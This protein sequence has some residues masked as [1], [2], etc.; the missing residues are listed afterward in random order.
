MV[1]L[2]ANHAAGVS[3]KAGN[4]EVGVAQEAR[5][6]IQL[7][8]VK[9][10]WQRHQAAVHLKQVSEVG[11]RLYIETKY[12]NLML[13]NKN[14]FWPNTLIKLKPWTF[15]SRVRDCNCC[16]REGATCFSSFENSD[17]SLCEHKETVVINFGNRQIRIGQCLSES[18]V[19]NFGIWSDF[20]SFR[21]LQLPRRLH[22][23]GRENGRDRAF[24]QMD[25]EK[26]ETIV[27][28]RAGV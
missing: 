22:R 8:N 21:A 13:I 4:V 17:E 18:A 3:K 25:V 16:T 24:D 2:E 14:H 6:E 12:L 7:W 15:S 1:V 11:G 10:V 27:Q 20:W 19:L 5:A 9:W 28:F 23:Y 26:L